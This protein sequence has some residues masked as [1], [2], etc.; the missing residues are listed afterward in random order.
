MPTV[1]ALRLAREQDLDLVEVA[2]GSV[3][4]VCRIL[5][6][7]KLR[8]LQAK[9]GREARKAQKSN[10]LREVRFRPNIGEHDFVAKIRKVQELVGE[11]DKVKV[12]VRFSGRENTRPERGLQLLKRVS[13]AVQ[14]EVRLDRPPSREGASLSIV[15]MPAS[16]K[17]AK[18]TKAERK[19]EVKSA[20]G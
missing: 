3:P 15:L 9:K 12:T 11:G 13:E 4:P 19:E 17:A 16:D 8:Y 18:T 14:D 10:E 6:Y 2:S 5:D 7:G 20:Q 1:E